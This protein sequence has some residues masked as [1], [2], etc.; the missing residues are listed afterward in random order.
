MSFCSF[1]KEFTANMFTCVENQFITK[2]LPQT[3]GD[4]VRVYLY[5][6]YL[7]SCKEAF[8]AEN[9]AKLLKLKKE[10]LVRIYDFWEECDLVRVL[11]REPLFV[12][13]LPV[14]AAVGKP[15]SIRPEK[16]S[17]FNRELLRRLQRAGKD[18]KPYEM[19]KILEFLENNEMEQSAFLLVAEYCIKKD[20]E[21]V[22][23]AHILNKAKK[24]CEN[25]KYTYEQ[26]EN[27]FSDFNRNESTLEKVFSLLG[28]LRKAQDSDYEL[29]EKWLQ[30]G[31]ET[32]AILAMAG[33]LKKGTLK[34]LD[35][36]AAELAEK[37][38]RTAS[39]AKEYL[40][41]REE[42][43]A[44]IY[45]VARKLGVSV[46]NPRAY[47]EEY[48]EK[49]SERGYDPESLLLVAGISF[50]LRYGFEEMDALLDS[51][52]SEGIV[53]ATGVKRY[54]DAR[55]RQFRLL[56]SVQKACGVVKKT[57]SALDMVATW[58]SWNFSEAMILEAAARSAGAAA[59]LSY[60]NK[61]LSEWKREGIFSPGEI[62]QKAPSAAKTD[63]RSE[64]AI[65][66]DR[67]TDREHH[68][69][70]LRQKANAAAESARKRAEADEGFR[71]A[72]SELRKGEIELA[73]AEVYS[74]ETAAEI[75]R[76]L[77]RAR[78]ERAAALGRLG[79]SETDFLPAF[80]CKK[81]SDTGY[82]PD[83]R[84]CDCYRN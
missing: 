17:D 79:L 66:A 11:S 80:S 42:L 81:C 45:R 43:A 64:A 61:L 10:D 51:L 40:Q 48:A 14:N 33:A 65:A 41:R 29:L 22:S 56:Q 38:V 71:A 73:K 8:D 70:V 58:Q 37:K 83:G 77:E 60:M 57:Q 72:E 18:F 68:Y 6:L 55:D 19:Q 23:C 31:F 3:D 53:D 54:C 32:G 67:R 13:Y 26:V 47:I 28:I 5:G 78:A 36:L 76:R 74:P 52:Y 63:L 9:V 4:A 7:C 30:D 39:E 62:A 69:A 44:V 12:E 27:E 16:Y 2:Y 15:K 50:K 84:P 24:L 35:V 20:G 59:P 34:T 82:L 46:Q 1:S 21:K 49:W 75:G 25:R